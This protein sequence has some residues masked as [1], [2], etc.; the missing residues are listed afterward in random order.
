ML[1]RAGI[2]FS[3][4][5]LRA[6]FT[7]CRQKRIKCADM[8]LQV[9][10]VNTLIR[11]FCHLRKTSLQPALTSYTMTIEK[12]RALRPLSAVEAAG[13][14]DVKEDYGEYGL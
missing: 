7:T 8:C 2:N 5:Q 3:L 9:N 1:I 13:V 4:E 11:H 12:T 10:Q 6:F 14:T